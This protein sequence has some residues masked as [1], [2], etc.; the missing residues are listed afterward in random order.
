M[1]ILDC[2]STACYLSILPGQR[3]DTYRHKK[4]LS[5]EYLSRAIKLLPVQLSLSSWSILAEVYEPV[6]RHRI[7]ACTQQLS[8]L[9]IRLPH[10][11]TTRDAE[12]RQLRESNHG[13][14]KAPYGQTTAETC[15]HEA[16]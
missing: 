3:A 2:G 14:D 11:F 5:V 15:I 8:D 13:I 4:T 12:T 16:C 1:H 6:N 7:A 9:D 10:G